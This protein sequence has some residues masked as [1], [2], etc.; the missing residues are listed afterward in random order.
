MRSEAGPRGNSWRASLA[1]YLLERQHHAEGFLVEFQ[2]HRHGQN[3]NERDLDSMESLPNDH[4]FDFSSF[5]TLH[6]IVRKS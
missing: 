1:S 3:Y 6:Q 2:S 4:S 5:L